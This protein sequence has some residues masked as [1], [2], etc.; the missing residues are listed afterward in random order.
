[1]NKKNKIPRT[2]NNQKHQEAVDAIRQDLEKWQFLV[3]PAPTQAG[4]DLEVTYNE[5]SKLYIGVVKMKHTTGNNESDN[6]FSAVSLTKWQKAV[7]DPNQYCFAIACE[8]TNG[9][10]DCSYYTVKEFWDKT[11]R[12]IFHL[13]C[14]L[15]RANLT[16]SATEIVSR[17]TSKKEVNGIKK[18]IDML[19]DCKKSWP[20]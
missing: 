20:K 18:C 9:T 14:H 16:H 1:M 17:L 19:R 12:P 4:Y 13:Y 3:N 15:N 5:N 10:F 7:N 6:P 2:T 11:S 8:N